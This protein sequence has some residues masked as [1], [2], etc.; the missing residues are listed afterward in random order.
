MCCMIQQRQ[1]LG[2]CRNQLTPCLAHTSSEHGAGFADH[3]M[4]TTA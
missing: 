3:K 1:Y 4:E 2:F